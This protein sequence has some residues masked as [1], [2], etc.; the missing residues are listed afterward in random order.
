MP[1]QL[2]QG[3]DATT[4]FWFV[5]YF[6]GHTLERERGSVFRDLSKSKKIG[7]FGF[8]KILRFLKKGSHRAAP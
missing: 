1:E 8:W 2:S 5:K 3:G 6:L 4:I 7:K